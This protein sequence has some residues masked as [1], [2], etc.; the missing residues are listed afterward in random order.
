MPDGGR[1]VERFQG[2][3]RSRFLVTFRL[4]NIEAVPPTIPA[5]TSIRGP[6]KPNNQCIN[7]QG[8]DY[9][10]IHMM[11]LAGL[12]SLRQRTKVAPRQGT[13]GAG[14][15]G[16]NSTWQMGCGEILEMGAAGGATATLLA[17][18]SDTEKVKTGWAQISDK[19][20]IPSP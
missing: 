1:L 5:G 9:P 14:T 3:E 7:Q 8:T 18:G 13:A 17:D 10:A 11:R 16:N 19:V 2:S 12:L 15:P 20:L 6:S 4:M